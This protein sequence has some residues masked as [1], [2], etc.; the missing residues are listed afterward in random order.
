V[1][2]ETSD[3]VTTSI[4]LL[5]RALAEEFPGR[6]REW[7][8]NVA[9]ALSALEVALRQHAGLAEKPDG[10]FAGVDLKRPT[11]IRQMNGLRLGIADFLAEVREL[12]GR[13]CQAAQ[14][15]QPPAEPLGHPDRLPAVVAPAAVPHF[16]ELRADV[17]EFLSR[18]EQHLEEETRLVLESVTTDI[19]AGD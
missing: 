1:T 9:G 3:P 11:F 14:A 15:F 2:R 19:G 18:L 17:E 12:R 16:G 7:G 10:L 6:E 4:R 5:E 13:V 8:E